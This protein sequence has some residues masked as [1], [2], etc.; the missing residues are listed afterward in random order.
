MNKGEWHLKI[1]GLEKGLGIQY[2]L[3][4]FFIESWVNILYGSAVT[5]STNK[6]PRPL[7]HEPYRHEKDKSACVATGGGFFYM[8]S[9][10]LG[11]PPKEA[12]M[13]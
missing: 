3:L 1:Y 11:S 8:S 5:F 13:E 9:D 7:N 10:S 6:I 12:D 2:F 4:Q